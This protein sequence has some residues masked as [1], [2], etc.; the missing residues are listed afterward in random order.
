MVRKIKLSSL[1]EIRSLLDAY[2]KLPKTSQK[3]E[4]QQQKLVLLRLSCVV[5]SNQKQSVSDRKQ[6]CPRQ[7]GRGQFQSFH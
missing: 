3:N 7:P 2:N 5:Y 1:N 6:M 4:T